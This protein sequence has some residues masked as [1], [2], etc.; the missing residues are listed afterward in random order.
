M[1]IPNTASSIIKSSPKDALLGRGWVLVLAAVLGV[2]AY[3]VVEWVKTPD[4]FSTKGFFT[5][6]VLWV[7]IGGAGFLVWHTVKA[8]GTWWSLAVAA[9]AVVVGVTLALRGVASEFPSISIPLFGTDIRPEALENK[10]D[11][12]VE[13]MVAHWRGFFRDVNVWALKVLVP[14][15]NSL[16]ALPWWLFVGL[17]GLLAWRVSGYKISLAS[18]VGLVFIAVLGMWDQSMRTLAVVGTATVMSV[19][20]A[21]PVGIAMAKSDWLDGMMRPVL[22]TMQTMPAFV[23]LIPIIY[24]LGLGKLPAVLATMVYA[25]PPAM[26]LTSLGIRLVPPEL[27]EAARSFGTSP[28]QLLVKVELPLAR[29][30]IMAGVNQ[31]TMMALAMVVIASIVGAQGLGNDVLAGIFNLEFGKGLIAGFGIVILAVII[32][33]ITQGFARE[34]NNSGR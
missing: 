19:A 29:P 22:D 24:F 27:K 9:A 33:R 16:L 34:A 15:E 25:V 20:V 32:D 6:F 5:Q 3:D 11:D 17:V 4:D 23:Y 30:T 14:I 28:W 31:T 12:A 1:D 7:F 8:L 2:M 13:W 10:V 26:R 18:M 21:V